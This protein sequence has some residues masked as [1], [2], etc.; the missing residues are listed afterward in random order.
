MIDTILDSGQASCSN[1]RLL[2]LSKRIHVAHVSCLCVRVFCVCFVQV[3]YSFIH[4][5]LRSASFGWPSLLEEGQVSRRLPRLCPKCHAPRRIG[6]IIIITI[7]IAICT[8]RCPFGIGVWA[9]YPLYK[10]LI[11]LRRTRIDE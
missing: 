11:H 9:A 6:V 5:P 2:L 10:C 7:A 3:F 4:L 8:L 1:W